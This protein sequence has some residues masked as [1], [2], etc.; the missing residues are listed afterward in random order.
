VLWHRAPNDVRLDPDEIER[1]TLAR[2]ALAMHT[3]QSEI[4]RW[5]FHDVA[6][7]LEVLAADREIERME[8][9]Q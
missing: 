1:L 4:K 6:D 3:P 7:L 9:R 2:L 8:S 5:N